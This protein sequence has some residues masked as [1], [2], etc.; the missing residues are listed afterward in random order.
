MARQ[1]PP[2]DGSACDHAGTQGKAAVVPRRGSREPLLSSVD[3]L[4]FGLGAVSIGAVPMAWVFVFLR[5]RRTR[6]FTR[7]DTTPPTSIVTTGQLR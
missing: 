7:H 2:H 3:W 5:R 4:A 1:D 6:A